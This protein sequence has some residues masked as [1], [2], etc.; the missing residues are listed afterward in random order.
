MTPAEL[1][2]RLLEACLAIIGAVSAAHGLSVAIEAAWVSRLRDKGDILLFIVGVTFM[3]AG[4][5]MIAIASGV[6]AP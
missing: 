5:F 6:F 2:A 1:A 3:G 4:L